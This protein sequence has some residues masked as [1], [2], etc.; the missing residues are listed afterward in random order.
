MENTKPHKKIYWRFFSSGLRLNPR[1]FGVHRAV[2][3]TVR[4]EFQSCGD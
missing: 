3:A 2:L 4:C 1:T